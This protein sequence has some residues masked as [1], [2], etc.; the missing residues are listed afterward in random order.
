MPLSPSRP[1]A[2]GA[3]TIGGRRFEWGRR[4]YI[5]GI[6]NLTPDSFSGDGLGTDVQAALERAR[7]FEAQGA[8][9]LDL[10]GESTRPSAQQVSVEEE[11]RR[12]LPVLERLQGTVALPLSVDTYKAA[13]ARRAVEAGA[14]LINNVQG[15]AGSPAP[16][17]VLSLVAAE[18]GVPLVI[19]HNHRGTEYNDLLSD[20][21][22]ELA[23]L[24]QQAREAGVPKGHIIV[25]PGLGFG[26]SP[27]QSLALLRH[28]DELQA[29]GQPLL[30]GPSRKSMIGAVLEGLPP[31]QRLEGTAAVVALAI[32]LG[33]D[34][35]RVHDV[36]AMAR[37]ARLADAV[38][39]GWRGP[40]DS[41]SFPGAGAPG[42]PS[43]VAL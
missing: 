30:V 29:L 15:P 10:G 23:V 24:V 41:P 14:A 32:A 35:V 28:L 34:I 12:V 43:G 27:A 38:A 36:G 31:D 19:A 37:V 39:R 42:R 16:D 21:K 3:L 13:V 17:P 1:G 9:L 5:M 6:L 40:Q 11:L 20:V 33:A 4:T 8:D 2:L 26:K 25:D 22:W 18:L 7:Q